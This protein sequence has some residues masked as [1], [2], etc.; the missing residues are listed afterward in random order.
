[1]VGTAAWFQD[2]AKG[3][4]NWV[5]VW[6]NDQNDGNIHHGAW[7]FLEASPALGDGQVD[8][9]ER[10]PRQRW[11]CQP[12]R[13]GPYPQNTTLVYAA[14][15]VR[16]TGVS[17]PMAWEPENGDV[18]GEDVSAYYRQVCGVTLSP[19]APDEV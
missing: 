6:K 18:P 17:Y 9:L 11:F 14:R 5:E 10:P 1:M 13:F 16:G 7:F 3:N 4:H 12:D 8:D 2:T 19:H 15:L